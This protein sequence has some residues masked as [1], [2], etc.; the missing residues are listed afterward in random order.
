[1]IDVASHYAIVAPLRL[2][3]DMLAFAYPLTS[4]VWIATI[5]SI[6]IYIIAMCMADYFFCGVV[7]WETNIGFVLRNTLTEHIEQSKVPDRRLYQKVLIVFWALP[8]G[9][10]VWAYSGNLT[11]M[12]T[13]QPI[14]SKRAGVKRA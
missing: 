6:P 9:I 4:E 7:D 8:L 12:I 5:I 3:P 10:I 11:A 14:Q 2:E 13:R 1:M